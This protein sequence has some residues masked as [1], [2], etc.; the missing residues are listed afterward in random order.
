MNAENR[1]AQNLL[2][3]GCRDKKRRK[4]ARRIH[5]PPHAE[6]CIYIPSGRKSDTLYVFL[7]AL[8]APLRKYITRRTGLERANIR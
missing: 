7:S 8:A 6:Q 4:W 5:R 2:G 3:C 1:P